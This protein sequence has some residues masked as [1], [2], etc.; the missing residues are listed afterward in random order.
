[1]REAVVV[2]VPRAARVDRHRRRAIALSA[3]ALLALAAA[4]TTSEAAIPSGAT[5][6]PGP[7]GGA[8][9]TAAPVPSTT[10]TTAFVPTTT[11]P[12]PPVAT[13]AAAACPVAASQPRLP[14]APRPVPVPSTTTPPG[15]A[16]AAAPVPGAAPPPPPPSPPTSASTTTTTTAPLTPEAIAERLR[17]D[18]RLAGAEVS[19]S[20]WV[21]GWGEIVDHG[22][23]VAL[24]P[25]SN[26]KLYTA[27]GALTLLDPAEHLHTDVVATGPVVDG[28]V[29]G[30]LVLVGGGDPWLTLQGP[31][32]IDALAEQVRAAGI[33]GVQGAVVVD[34]SRYDAVRTVDAWPGD[35]NYSIG[36]LSA[37]SADHNMFAKDDPAV[38][39]DPAPR[40]G[41]VLRFALMARGVA[42]GEPVRHGLAPAGVRLARVESPTVSELV[43]ELLRSSDNM[44][45]ELLVKEIGLRAAGRPGTTAAGLA[46]IAGV[47]EPL[48]GPHVGASVDGSGLSRGNRHSARDLR[49]VLQA[50]ALAPWGRTYVEHLPVTGPSNVLGGRLADPVAAG[51]VRAKGGMLSVTRS[52]SGYLTTVGGRTGVFSV[53][54]N[55]PRLDR[56]VDAAVDDLVTSVIQIPG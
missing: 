26:Q 13:P 11:V 14:A 28:V 50:A 8:D 34:E 37:L 2:P 53:L 17:T 42:I 27:I 45:A 3:M 9:R 16:P 40:I 23:D 56:R 52:L 43:V 41:E 21:D 46:A 31:A 33:V 15:G 51:R 29:Q 7:A 24:I 6:A 18:P 1:M 22:A 36:P 47:V 32:S 5:S 35:W 38:L 44:V 10:A 19:V 54:V 48:C 39:A 12:A 30:D 20:V 25:A 55:G 4:C 49:R